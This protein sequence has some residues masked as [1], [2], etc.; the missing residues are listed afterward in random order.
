MLAMKFRNVCSRVTHVL[1]FTLE[2]L[3]NICFYKIMQFGICMYQRR[4]LNVVCIK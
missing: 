3:A 2:I 1:N 4:S